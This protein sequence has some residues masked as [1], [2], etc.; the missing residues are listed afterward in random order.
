MIDA[1]K[2]RVVPQVPTSVPIPP[3][4]DT[5]PLSILKNTLTTSSPAG[6]SLNP[7]V[8]SAVK[9]APSSSALSLVS[10]DSE[11]SDTETT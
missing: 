6:P 8:S 5:D 4:S 9:S 7:V 3:N 2:K 11:D 1:V 10:Y